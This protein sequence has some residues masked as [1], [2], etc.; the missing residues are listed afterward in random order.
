VQLPVGASL[1]R[2]TLALCKL[3]AEDE[4]AEAEQLKSS[5]QQAA[6][7][8][9]RATTA[10]WIEALERA[11]LAGAALAAGHSAMH[12]LRCTCSCAV[13]ERMCF[14]ETLARF[15]GPTQSSA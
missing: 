8:S 2:R 11:V 4:L 5:G 6:A 7:W 13:H 3:L 9:S 14:I 15:G 12:T 10:A 1:S